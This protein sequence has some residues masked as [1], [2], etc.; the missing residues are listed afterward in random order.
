MQK[1]LLF[2]FILVSPFHVQSQQE[3]VLIASI[4]LDIDTRDQKG[5]AWVALK[6]TYKTGFILPVTNSNSEIKSIVFDPLKEIFD[7]YSSGNITADSFS[8]YIKQNTIDITNIRKWIANGI[9]NILVIKKGPHIFTLIPD[10]DHDFS[11][12]NNDGYT[13]AD[14]A[15]FSMVYTVPV[16]S[17]KV[18]PFKTGVL[19]AADS[20]KLP[21]IYKGFNTWGGTKAIFTGSLHMG[22]DS[23]SFKVLNWPSRLSAFGKSNSMAFSK[24]NEQA[25]DMNNTIIYRANDTINLN[26]HLV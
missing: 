20:K 14:T 11:F 2:L 15:I 23:F 4:K 5:S 22:M 3:S 16:W 26:G 8:Q 12:R 10:V 19:I 21:T 17:N 13:V 7:K 1:T 24:R 6:T 9:L 18:Y 25:I